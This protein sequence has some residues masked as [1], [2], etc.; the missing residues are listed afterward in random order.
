MNTTTNKK[1]WKE[2]VQLELPLDYSN[3]KNKGNKKK[4]KPIGAVKTVNGKEK[5]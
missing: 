1:E 2:P 4:L 5:N 3:C